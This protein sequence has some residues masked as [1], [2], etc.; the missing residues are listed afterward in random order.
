MP[1]PTMEH[2]KH[3]RNWVMGLH[4]ANEFTSLASRHR[5]GLSCE[6]GTTFFGSF[7]I[8]VRVLFDDG[9]AW[10]VRLPLP[11]RLLEPHDHTGKEVAI[12][13][14]L[15][16]NTKIPVPEIIAYGY[17][18]TACPRVGPFLITEFVLGIPLEDWF[19]D[20]FYARDHPEAPPRL[21]TD[22]EE[23]NVRKIYKQVA[24]ILLELC[25]LKFPSIGTLSAGHETSDSMTMPWTLTAHE[26]RRNHKVQLKRKYSLH[27]L[28]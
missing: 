19:K 9:V 28:M 6:C 22:I 26:A 18:D 23:K 8:C 1:A 15:R 4:E 20:R 11:Y 16:K 25:S 3:I 17:N 12:L 24:A 7:H 13:Q 21:R 27:N 2:N 14:Y 5:N 10:I